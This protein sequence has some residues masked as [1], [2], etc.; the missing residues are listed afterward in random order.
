MKKHLMKKHYIT[1]ILIICIIT[2]AGYLA[3]EHFL[4]PNNYAL[5]RYESFWNDPEDYDVW[6]MGSSHSYY[7]IYPMK[8]YERYGITSYDVGTPSCTLPLTYWTLMNAL[9]GGEPDLVFV[10]V[11]HTDMQNTLVDDNKKIHNSLDA[12]PMSA[13]KIRAIQDLVDDPEL[14]REL[15][16]PRFTENGD[17]RSLTYPDKEKRFKLNKGATLNIHSI[18]VEP[19]TSSEEL[20]DETTGTEYLRKIIHEC[21]SRDIDLVVT[22]FPFNGEDIKLQGM[23]T[24]ISIAQENGI[25]VLDMSY[26]PEVIDYRYDFSQ[27]GHLN[28]S[29]SVKMTSIV[30]EYLDENYNLTDHR[31]K[32]DSTRKKWDK[33]LSKYKKYLIKRL[34]KAKK[35]DRHLLLCEDENDFD[36]YLYI[37]DGAKLDDVSEIIVDNLHEDQFLTYEQAA[38][39]A[40]KDFDH[41]VVTVIKDAD[42]GSVVSISSF[43]K[44]KRK[45]L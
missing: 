28:Y 18:P 20:T 24:G 34:S 31:K 8:L 32:D 33:E 41:D 12:I 6:F 13:T 45:R 44:G 15:Y 21:K 16:F 42:T 3:A 22:A 11:Y 9:E 10:D 23:N 5:Y 39:Y 26:C 1:A 7:S 38:A 29:G 27:D 4:S 37:R 14:R 19:N 40:G 43:D 17:Y 2:G 35:L 25:P 36:L 30:G